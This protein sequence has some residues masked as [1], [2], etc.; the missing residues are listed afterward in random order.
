MSKSIN[1]RLKFVSFIKKNLSQIFAITE[2][3]A[4]LELRYKFGLI[5]S[6]ISPIISIIFPLIIMGRLFEYNEQFGS[7]NS[8]NYFVFLFIAYNIILLRNIISKF[9]AGIR[10]EKFWQTL[11]GLIIA[12]FN[13]FNLLLGIFCSHL[14]VIF[15]PFIILFIICFFFYPITLL[16]VLSIILIYFLIALIFSGVGLMLGIFAVSKESTWRF[17]LFCINWIFWFSCIT[18][19]FELFPNILQVVI[20]LNP[21]YHIFDFLR[22]TWIEDNFLLTIVSHPYSFIVLIGSSIVFPMI[23]VYFFNIIYKKYGIVGY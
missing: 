8:D 6:F 20:N 3:N 15:I 4:K 11:P 12:P 21:L 13:R 17:L 23:G 22:Q 14:I 10:Q 5:L 16:T 1:F 7:W 9:P 18:Y 19:P 2:K